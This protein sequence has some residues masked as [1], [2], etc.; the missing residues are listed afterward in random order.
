MTASATSRTYSVQEAAARTG[1]SEHTLRYYER[2]GLIAPVQRDGSS[3][4]RRY[5][6]EDLRGI[7]FLKRLRATGMHICDMQRYMALFQQGDSTLDERRAM[8]EEH[9]RRVREQ[10][11]ELQGHLEVIDYKIS[12]Y[13]R[14]GVERDW[15]GDECLNILARSRSSHTELEDSGLEGE[16]SEETLRREAI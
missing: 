2:V 6:E 11:A 4:H 7:E 15:K 3:K 12:N 10:I 14:L 8:L 16:D 5:S 9:G 1:L 13:R